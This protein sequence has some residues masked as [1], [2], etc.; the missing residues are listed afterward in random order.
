[1]KPAPLSRKTALYAVAAFLI[2]VISLLIIYKV[3]GT[4]PFG[5]NS[6]LVIDMNNQYVS[7]FSYLQEILKGNHD[8]IYSFSKTLGGDLIGLSAYYLVSPLNLLLLP[9]STEQLPIALE[10][11]TLLKTGLC[12]LSFFLCLHFS[13]DAPRHNCG[14]LIFPASY[15]LMSY[16]VVYQQN[17]MWLD[18][19]IL[20]PLVI[21]GIHRIFR[22]KSPF[23]YLFSLFFAIVTNY[24][25]GFMICIFSVLYF[26]YY[27]IFA[28]KRKSFWD[29]KILLNYGCASLAAGGLSMWLLIPVLK[30][31][32][33][34]KAAFDLSAFT[35][36]PNFHWND[37]LVKFFNGSFDYDQ[38]VQG[39]PNVYCG[40]AGLLF[41]GLFF[42]NGKTAL[43]K[44]LGALFLFA[45]L[46]LSF[47][48]NGAN[49]IWHGFNPP[50]WFPY[51]YSF[52]FSFLILLLAWEGF[53]MGIQVKLPHLALA[54]TV[55]LAG[56]CL[57]AFY[58]N[59]KGFAFMTPVKFLI[60]VSVVAL[61][62]LLY[63][64]YARGGFRLCLVALT[65]VC[66]ADLCA[67]GV[68]S[69]SV[70]SYR[71]MAYFED[72]VKEAQPAV[73]Y[74]RNMDGG[75]YRME[76]TFAR[77]ENDS[78]LLNYNGLSHYSS[79]EKSVVK[80]FMGQAGFRNTGNWA[81]YTKGST[82]AMDSLLNVKYILSKG[83]LGS[84]YNLVEKSGE[85]NIY[86]NPYALPLG[87]MADDSI[88]TCTTENNH[89]FQLQ[90]DIWKSLDGS[91][92]EDVF[93]EIPLEDTR[94]TNVNPINPDCYYVRQDAKKAAYVE[95]IFTAPDS[96][97]VFAYL[98]TRDMH[99]MKIEVNGTPLKE[100]SDT[101]QYTILRLGSFQK[102]ETVTVR[103]KLK[104]DLANISNAWF[105]Q[106]D[107]DVF[108]S[109]Y[110]SLSEGGINLTT[111]S[112]SYMAGTISNDSSREY[113]FFSIP[114]EENWKVYV[115]G[116]PVET[117]P[118]AGVFL[119]A[120]V[121]QGDHSIELRYVPA[122]RTAGL[123]L[124]GITL[125][126]VLLW[127]GIYLRR[128]SLPAE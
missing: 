104:E 72:F 50:A 68:Y 73:E 120:K 65:V 122:G 94:L 13:D 69:L 96:D 41:L 20:L 119:T 52:V 113:L 121:P 26:L 114:Y 76:K 38:I 28:D 70:F 32:S 58:M 4:Y 115:D 66:C 3:I 27:Y 39:M 63:L 78:M 64:L 117:A 127:I 108:D 85:V 24:Y 110:R 17:L 100:Y 23:L 35:M 42:L 5:E 123:V 60:S 84:P 91:I 83:S 77:N 54:C 89:K 81:A 2:P 92:G 10:I 90:N 88:L 106:Q 51:R 21:L 79:S 55:I 34:G 36:T 125:A 25:I 118:G 8:F 49:L 98:E 40:M 101:P 112:D 111:A 18:G 102:D 103:V 80:D 105:Y 59:R 107:M 57:C 19:V 71:T 67:N 95:Y 87:F 44:K 99:K 16:S 62:I 124:T 11:I 9:F 128:S 33:G 93:T 43:R 47:Y 61:C 53:S 48:L 109:Y 74:V 29:F 7:F 75:F 12:G 46:F 1:M 22:K 82:Y 86:E 116:S 97:P 126:A 6:L 45:I 56:V 15:A 14:S 37:F 30:S 31:L